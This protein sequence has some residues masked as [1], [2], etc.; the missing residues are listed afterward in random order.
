[1]QGGAKAPVGRVAG[2]D[3]ALLARGAGDRA[4]PGVVLARTRGREPA[5]V[6]AELAEGA[7]GEDDSVARLAEVNVS[8]RVTAKMLSHHALQ[9]GDLCVESGDDADLSGNDSCIGALQRRW[10]TQRR[11]S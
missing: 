9:G 1:M 7:R 6:V 8:S 2:Q 4:L 5:L 11:G 10:L 3:D